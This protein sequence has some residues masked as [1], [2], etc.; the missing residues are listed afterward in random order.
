MNMERHGEMM[1]TRRDR[2]TRREMCPIATLPTTN[3]TWTDTSAN[4]GLRRERPA[5]NRLSHDTTR[6]V[7]KF[8]S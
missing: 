3:L 5:T 7:N 6:L 2:R 4:L 8:V 1:L